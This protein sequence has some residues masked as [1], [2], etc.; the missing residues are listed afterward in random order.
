MSKNHG[1]PPQDHVAQTSGW[2]VNHR[3]N[4]ALPGYLMIASTQATNDLSDLSAKALGT[5]F[6]KVQRGLNE[7]GARRVDIGR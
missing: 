5:V 1:I 6:A 3:V 7:L 2:S 4:S